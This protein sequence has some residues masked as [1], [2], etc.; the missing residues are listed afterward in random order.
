M[1]PEN[2]EL[3][4]HEEILS[5]CYKM[6]YVFT[7][8]VISL[9]ITSHLTV[10][11]NITVTLTAFRMANTYYHQGPLSDR[12]EAMGAFHHQTD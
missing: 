10:R 7:N 9:H 11:E 1:T 8:H 12:D 2:E 4:G 6:C 3:A 5:L